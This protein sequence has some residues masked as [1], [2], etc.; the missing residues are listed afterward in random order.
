MLVTPIVVKVCLETRI[1]PFP[2]L[3]AICTSAN[4]GSG[5]TLSGNPQ[6]I[7]IGHLSKVYL[8]QKI[9]WL[10]FLMLCLP[11][12]IV[13]LLINTGLLVLYYRKDINR[14]QGNSLLTDQEKDLTFATE[15]EPAT[16]K[17][18]I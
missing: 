12:A 8:Y 18:S 13:G 1:D 2:F 9:T 7:L 6:N 17:E 5:A 11:G 14:V 15:D 3:V 4:I 16:T 10:E